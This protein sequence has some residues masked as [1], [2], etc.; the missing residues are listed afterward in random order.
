MFDRFIVVDWSAANAPKRGKDTIW[1]ADSRKSEPQNPRTRTEAM[2]IVER[3]VAEATDDARL[4]VGF[5]FAFGYP[6][7]A[8]FLP[9]G[10][11]WEEVWAYLCDAIEDDE[12][13]RSNRFAVGAA[14]NRRFE[15]DGPFWGHPH[16]HRG[17]YD[18]LVMRRPD[19]DRLGLRERR[20]IDAAVPKAQPVWKL[21]YSGSVGS[22]ALTGIARLEALRKGPHREKIAVWPFETA[23][24]ENLERPVVLAEIYPSLWPIKARPGEVLDSAQVRTLLQGFVRAQEEGRFTEMLFGPSDPGK[25]AEALSHEAWMVGFK[26]A[27][28]PL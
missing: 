22:Q 7:D 27:R 14:L 9:G 17:R 4:F 12:R 11:R 25:R 19:Y 13:N 16:Q 6:S 21:A 28:L 1:I 20:H 23:F 10:G 8:A 3:A 5:D 24:A 15:G 26:D 2:N 18:G